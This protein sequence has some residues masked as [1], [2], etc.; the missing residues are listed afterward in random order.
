MFTGIGYSASA[1]EVNQDNF[2]KPS[3]V[4][5]LGCHHGCPIQPGDTELNSDYNNQTNSITSD[6]LVS[7]SNYLNKINSRQNL[8]N[9]AKQ[10]PDTGENDQINKGSLLG[11]LLAVIG[12]IFIL[13][14]RKNKKNIEK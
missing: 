12:S 9:N 13:A 3:T 1:S 7:S 2:N 10:L 8:K 14:R 5:F 4:N 6:N 11:S